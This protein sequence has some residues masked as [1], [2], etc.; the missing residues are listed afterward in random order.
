M[1]IEG[2]LAPNNSLQPIP[3]APYSVMPVAFLLAFPSGKQSFIAL[4]CLCELRLQ[5]S[6]LRSA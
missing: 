1:R 5:P 4:S 2:Y 3:P 6:C